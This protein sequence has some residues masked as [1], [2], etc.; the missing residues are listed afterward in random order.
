[1][2]SVTPFK[3]D[4]TALALSIGMVPWD[5]DVFGFPV[6]Q[7]ETIRVFDAVSAIADFQL[8][9]EWLNRHGVRMVSCRLPHDKLEESFLLEREGFKFIEMVLHPQMESLRAFEFEDDELSVS[10]AEPS[11][12]PVL[13]AIAESAFGSER[14]HV[15]P[16]VD[17]GRADARYG[18]WVSSCLAHPKQ[19]LLKVMS[20]DEIVALFVVEILNLGT[21]YWHLTAVAPN[22]QGKGFGR[23]AWRAMMRH[24]KL[25]KVE[26]I[27]TTISARNSRVLNLYARLGFRFGSPE[28]TFHFMR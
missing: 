25:Q 24:H 20:G 3:L 8:A 28:T 9:W 26:S 6:A 4:T 15:D 1:M 13:I 27:K 19:V 10:P 2:K 11:D 12:L 7:V 18:N 21:A 17:T 22:M 14:F 5:S 23:R 16:R